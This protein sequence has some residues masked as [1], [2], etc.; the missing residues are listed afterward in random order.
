MKSLLSL[1]LFS[2]IFSAHAGASLSS[3]RQAELHELLIDD[4]GSCHGSRLLGGLGPALTQQHV[5]QFS[6]Q[7]LID[8]VFN[9]RPGTAMPPW[10]TMLSYE[11][12]SWI[13]DQLRKGVKTP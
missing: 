5:N 3:A 9:G 13:V 12:V 8:S 1:F 11:E 10:N 6:R 4:C 2:A 7:F